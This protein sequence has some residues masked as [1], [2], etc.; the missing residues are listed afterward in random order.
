MNE[1]YKEIDIN[2][3]PDKVLLRYCIRDLKAE[4][5]E[6][7]K[8][9]SYI[10]ELQKENNILRFNT[11]QPKITY[12]LAGV[13]KSERKEALIAFYEKNGFA[14]GLDKQ[15][16]SPKESNTKLHRQIDELKKVRDTLLVEINKLK[17]KYGE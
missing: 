7:G 17:E 3:I 5:V 10:E 8:L 6:V 16:K 1:E 14:N 13:P 2:N 15:T 9:K 11:A 12:S 4:R